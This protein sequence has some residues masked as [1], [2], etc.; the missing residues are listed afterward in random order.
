MYQ[1]YSTDLDEAGEEGGE[2]GRVWC[3]H[4]YFSLTDI[5][6]Y[7]FD[8]KYKASQEEGGYEEELSDDEGGVIQEEYYPSD[9]DP[10]D[11]HTDR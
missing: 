5:G 2:Y 3:W 9:I 1:A 10:Y 7:Y 8:R 6:R 11:H 4:D